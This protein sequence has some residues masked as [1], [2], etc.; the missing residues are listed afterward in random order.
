[1]KTKKR[2]V[3][4]ILSL[5][6]VGVGHFYI[7]QYKKAFFILLIPFIF[8]ALATLLFWENFVIVMLLLLSVMAVYLYG[9]VDVW[10]SFPLT[11]EDNSSSPWYFVVLYTIL[12]FAT[13]LFFSVNV[14]KSFMIP[15]AAM[16][17]TI[18]RGDAFFVE[19]KTEIERG[20]V[21]VFQ[22]P[23][24]P[25][26][27]FV[28]RMVAKG[29]DELVYQ[30]KHLYI[31]FT[32][33]DNFMMKEYSKEKLVKFQG[34]LWIDNPYKIG[35]KKIQYNPEDE[36]SFETLINLLDIRT[37]MRPIY[38]KELG[39]GI[40]KI[41]KGVTVNAF[42]KKIEENHYYMLGDNRDNSADSRFWGSVPSNYIYG[43]AKVI[44]FNKND[45]SRI[46]MP[47]K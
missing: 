34:K 11:K 30:D 18:M 41:R 7:T 43:I 10:R 15:S 45:L 20:D 12:A 24:S 42:Y 32:E 16:E 27:M 25:K 5:L 40:F 13:Q 4:V 22:Y 38:I 31:H 6:M 26:T 8:V 9:I 28:K 1:M 35:N 47:I 36:N 39:E 29:G 44:Y 23:L 2:W 19:K 14:L 3:A 33:G 17:G 21:V 37:D 46:G